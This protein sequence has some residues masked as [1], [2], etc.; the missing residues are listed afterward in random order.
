MFLKTISAGY[1]SAFALTEPTAGSDSGG[2]KTTARA[3][4]RRVH[5]DDDGV[6]WFWLDEE[7][8]RHR[9]NL[10]DADRVEHDYDERRLLYRFSDDAAPALIDHSEY[11]YDKDAAERTRFY[12]H[13]DR[14][15]QFGDIGQLRAD[16]SGALFYEYWVLN[17]AKMW[18]T[19]GRFCHCMAL[20]ALT[21][22][23]G[24]TGFMVDRHAEGLV[25]GADEEKLGQRGSPTNE[26]SLN[27][28][29]VPH[30][31]II[32]FRGH[33]QVNAL[34]T[35]NTGRAGLAVATHATI[36][37]LAADAIP[38]LRGETAPGFDYSPRRPARPLERYWMG[39]VAEELVGTAAVTYEMIGLL[40]NKHTTSVRMES[41]IGKYYGTESE[42]DC[43][44][45][46]ER[47]RG[48][49]GQTWLHR[50]EKTRRDARVLNIYE[51]TNEVQRFLL[52]K[53][54]VQRVLPE[55]KS[56]DGDLED[57]A[58]D[59][60]GLDDSAP[61]D[62][63]PD[64]GAPGGREL[65][66]PE[67]A[68]MLD[69][70]RRRLL[71]NVDAAVERFGQLV[72][73]NVGLQPCFFRLAEI[74]GLTKVIDAVLYRLEWC[75]RRQVPE[76]Y[77]A[78]LEGAS[79]LYVQRA[80]S[81]IAALQRRYEIA[82]AYLVEGRYS[83]ETQLGFLSLEEAEATAGDWHPVPEH[84]IDRAPEP[85][86]RRNIEIAV[87]LKP[88]PSSAPRPRLADGEFVEPL[89]QVNPA[90]D[91]ALTT[92]LALKQR[93]PLHIDVS[94]YTVAMTE[95]VAVLRAALSRGADRAVHLDTTNVAGA[96]ALRHD[97]N[98]VARLT[99]AALSR[100]PADLVLCGTSAAD[101]GQGAV[102]S[103]LASILDMEI[104][105]AVESVRW[106][107]AAAETLE[108]GCSSWGQH[109]LAVQTPCV[110]ATEA[111]PGEAAHYDIG[112]WLRAA[113]VEVERFSA[114]TLVG[115]SSVVQVRH[116]ARPV[117]RS[118]GRRR[119]IDSPEDAA[120]MV[121]DV[122]EF[123]GA[124]AADAGVYEHRLLSLGE[125]PANPADSCLF[126]VAP[127]GAELAAH[128]NV[129]LRLARQL[130]DRVGMVLDVVV[131]V[132]TDGGSAEAVAGAVLAAAR[133]RR[134]YIVAVA[135]ATGFST[136]GHLEW[137]EEFWAMYRATPRW[138]L[139]S[140]WANEL[141]AR[142]VAGGVPSLDAGR[143]WSW[144]NVDSISSGG[145]SIRVGTR[146][147][148]GSALAEAE[149]PLV[150]GLRVLTLGRTVE[151]DLNGGASD[152]QEEQPQVYR[153][154][155]E[156]EYDASRDPLA[157]FLGGLE[158][159]R[160]RLQ[161]AE[162]IIDFGYGAGG[163]EGIDVL[164]EPLRQLLVDEMG[165]RNVMIGATRKVTQDLELLPADRQIGQ[166]GVS[167]NPKLIIALAVSGAPQHVD[168]IGDRAV[169]LSFNID[170]E[171]PLMKLNEQRPTPI[172]HPI[173][174][175]VWDTVPRFMEAIRQRLRGARL[176]AG[177]Q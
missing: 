37:E 53:D 146:I 155:P 88:V 174:G 105:G 52:L 139:A 177:R 127:S 152:R 115:D 86:L 51:G 47:A 42:H 175:D 137:L 140:S 26:L 117:A 63:T 30:E 130:A 38:Y 22:P 101:T 73:A 76:E 20:Y 96:G 7:N 40:D 144:H 89:R 147:Y 112:A 25:V 60:S 120:G 158:S 74:A 164:A 107:D 156:L 145:G 19:N 166:T 21:D 10:L 9:R 124:A 70:A 54:L 59:D 13:G 129:E 168:Y 109:E 176:S 132:D 165:L 114:A 121:I 150:G 99:A 11:D 133:P 100:R 167:V 12:M 87:L 128:A 80:L 77:R 157:R 171:A 65:A 126:V 75:A 32:G 110:L 67:L 108:I 39:R 79:Q 134:V 50:I 16:N 8:E 97:S 102:P 64:D 2:V 160:G 163:R 104:F 24:V 94:V 68:A 148:G 28:V 66:N 72:W 84:L 44:D 1:I 85:D 15:V 78:R 149:L 48:L 173:V 123:G 116:L 4:R 61:D 71:G 6:L 46:M 125:Q 170:P 31:A 69:Q 43:I 122:A 159:S 57:S 90:D 98:Y 55:W 93:D 92:A 153:W 23:E 81:R 34:E 169:V 83:P 27:N 118:N 138:L 17:G 29:R 18:I 103:Y 3:A 119:R 151:L 106:A 142:F 162:I 172:V 45:W 143:C 91:A 95:G 82:L 111:R 161:D 113:T 36:G 131:P 56:G 135:G 5:R 136:R 141:F 33:G 62:G 154:S 58:P 35:L 49:E 41:A 14:K